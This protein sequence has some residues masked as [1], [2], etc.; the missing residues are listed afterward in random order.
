MPLIEAQPNALAKVYAKSLF[1]LAQ[2]HGGQTN[3]E[4]ILGE[5]EDIVELARN[6]NAF[7]ELLASRLID[8]GKRD[9]SLER[10]FSGKVSPLTLNFLR[11][12]NRK[13]RLANLSQIATAMD[14][15]VQDQFGRIEVDVYTATPIGTGELESVRK[16]L[17]ESLGKDVIMHPYTDSSML[18]GIKLSM[19]DQL[20]D[21][22]IQAQLSKMRDELL[23]SGSA[24]IRGR[25]NDLL[26]E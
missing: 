12:I 5:L 24:E 10:M 9:A 2:Q 6:D 22:S 7:S 26:E 15:L 11:Q 20:I 14:A 8:S 17:S 19:G 16:Q 21:A 18:G 13:G 3:A 25:S 4:S 1:E 23:D